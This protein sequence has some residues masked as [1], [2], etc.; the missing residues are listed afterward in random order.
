MRLKASFSNHRPGLIAAHFLQT[1]QQFG[2]YPSCV[3][4]DCGTENVTVA[5]IQAFVTGSTASHV[6]GTAPGNQRIESRWAFFHRSGSQWWLE[7]F[8]SLHD[9]G[10]FH[11]GSVQVRM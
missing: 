1:A 11:P 3:R 4:T 7:L 10:A 5:A 6:H 2:G 9:F 8:E